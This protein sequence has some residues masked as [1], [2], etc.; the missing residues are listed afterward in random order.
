MSRHLSLTYFAG[1]TS[2]AECSELPSNLQA[3]C[4][5]RWQWYG[6]LHRVSYYSLT[7]PIQGLAVMSTNGRLMNHILST[8]VY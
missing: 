8:L 4:H 5:W 6:P 3:G 2:D 1:V 7:D